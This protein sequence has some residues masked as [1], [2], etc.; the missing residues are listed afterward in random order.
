MYATRAEVLDS[1]LRG[2]T[3]I[4]DGTVGLGI[5]VYFN[6]ETREV[7]LGCFFV[8]IKEITINNM[9]MNG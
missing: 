1:T 4:V 9:L 2:G 5:V 7:T 3:R 6:T 8:R